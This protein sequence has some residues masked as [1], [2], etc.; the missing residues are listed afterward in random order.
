[1]KSSKRAKTDFEILSFLAQN[2]PHSKREIAK[3]LE[4]NYRSIRNVMQRLLS[5][6]LIKVEFK[7]PSSKNSKKEVEYY[8]LTLLGLLNTRLLDKE[9]WNQI[10]VIAEKNYRKLLVFRKWPLF[11]FRSLRKEIIHSFQDTLKS[12]VHARAT[13]SLEWYDMKYGDLAEKIDAYVLGSPALT[14]P[15]QR[16]NELFGDRFLRIWQTCKEDPQLRMFLEHE[17]QKRKRW[18]REK[19]DAVEKWEEWFQRTSEKALLGSV[20]WT[21]VTSK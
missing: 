6:K 5:S 4:K 15:R 2:K 21:A 10:D 14:L 8:G 1:M 19:L 3:A 18:T 12:L 20:N 11:V 13:A 9:I 7:K 16:M 17:I